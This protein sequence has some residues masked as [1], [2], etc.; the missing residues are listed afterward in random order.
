MKRISFS[1]NF[2][3]FILFFGLALLEAIQT[4]NWLTVLFWIAVGILFLVADNMKQAK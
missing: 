3:L 1:T 4:R 2:T